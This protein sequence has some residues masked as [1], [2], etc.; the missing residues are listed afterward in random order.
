[1]ATFLPPV[2]VELMANIKDFQAKQ[3]QVISGIKEIETVGNSTSAKMKVVGSRVATGVLLGAGAVAVVSLKMAMDF[4]TSMTRLVTGAGEA[5]ENVALLNKGFLE[6]AGTVGST[7]KALADGFYNIASA[8]FHGAEGLK[9]LQASA[10]GAKIGGTELGVVSNALTTALNSY[11]LGAEYA[12]RMTSGMVQTVASGKTT[13]EQLAGSL[14]K[15]LPTASNLGVKYNDVAGALATMTAQGWS[16]DMASE[17]LNTMMISLVAPTT[18][19]SNVLK[20]IGLTAQDLTNS[21]ADPK[22]GLVGTMAMLENHISKKFP[23]GSALYVQA[24][25]SLTGGNEGFSASLMLTGGHMKTYQQNVKSI[26]DAMG[27]TTEHVQGWT[28]VQKTLKQQLDQLTGAGSALAINLGQWLLPKAT[29]V[30]KWINGA[31]E[32]FKKHPG[33]KKALAITGGAVLGASFL[34]KV[35][36]PL[37]KVFGGVKTL[38]N[39]GIVSANTLASKLN[40]GAIN[41]LT[42]VIALAN[43]LPIPGGGPGKKGL[44][45]KG[46][47][48]IKDK[49]GWA[50]S[51]I[52][53]LLSGGGLKGFAGRAGG[54]VGG[55]VVG[56]GILKAILD[57]FVKLPEMLRNFGNV[58]TAINPSSSLK[59]GKT[60]VTI[61]AKVS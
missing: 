53:G 20:Y 3:K 41:R 39:K 30:V 40:T 16:A 49:G 17:R 31:V 44:I 13:M 34:S 19:A 7:P 47:D 57:K 37:A 60:T 52:T 10:E 9:V 14:G 59:G 6:L 36:G 45:R 61:K 15:I 11:G 22:V 2:V 58:P 24:M 29:A 56:A 50:L 51:G 21:L 26:G 35:V 4:E 5:R 28:D 48:W 23:R 55:A 8:G 38:F 12:T 18:E 54:T 27:K 33:W 42:E 43:K 32:E 46:W 25:K 1:M